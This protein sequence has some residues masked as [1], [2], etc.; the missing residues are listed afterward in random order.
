LDEFS[1]LVVELSVFLFPGSM[2]W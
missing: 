1:L 2:D